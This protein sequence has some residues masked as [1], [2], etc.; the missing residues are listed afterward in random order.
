MPVMAGVTVADVLL[1]DGLGDTFSPDVRAAFRNLMEERADTR[2]EVEALLRAKLELGDESVRG[3][4]NKVQGQIGEDIFVR[5]A[6]GHA[7]LAPSGSQRDWD[8]RIVDDQ[9]VAL[10]HVRH[11]QVKVYEDADAA[12]EKLEALHARLQQGLVTDGSQVLQGVDFAVNPEIFQEVRE[13]AIQLGYPGDVLP[14]GRTRIDIRELLEGDIAD[15]REPFEHFFGELLGDVAN[16]AIVQALAHGYLLLTRSRDQRG[17]AADYGV[18]ISISS[19]G[20]VTAHITEQLVDHILA[21]LDYG[22]GASVLAMEPSTAAA[23]AAGMATRA[24]LRRVILE[25]LR[26][27]TWLQGQNA[28][29]IGLIEKLTTSPV[30]VVQ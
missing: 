25:R 27:A 21:A 19:G 8:V 30:A 6:G 10:R 1:G 14:L 15:V 7:A 4:M 20:V 29:L 24:L 5:G 16:V 22:D 12:I 11:V 23:L 18:S 26:F 17:A 28:A 9:G 2:H 13:R 3:L